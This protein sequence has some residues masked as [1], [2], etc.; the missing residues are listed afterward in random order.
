MKFAR[1]G[2][3]VF[4]ISDS[5]ERAYK[6]LGYQISDTYSVADAEKKPKKE[7]NPAE[8]TNKKEG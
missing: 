3:H 8:A 5:D 2:N 4:R 6:S 1:K 7:E